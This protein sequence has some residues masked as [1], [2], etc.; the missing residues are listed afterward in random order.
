MS[1]QPAVTLERVESWLTGEDLVF[2]H[3]DEGDIMVGFENCYFAF[4]MQAEGEL[5]LARA[6]WRGRFPVGQ[7]PELHDLAD[8]HHQK[9]YGPRLS[10]LTSPGEE[11]QDSAIL[12]TQMVEYVAQG[13][14][15][16]QLAA[17]M[18]LVMRMNMRLFADIE[19]RYPALV[20]WGDD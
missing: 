12:G 3:D 16:E 8:A 10:V 11:G 18:D 14:S 19:E 4:Y 13:R 6:Y 9:T 15:D 1:T 2:E 7:M 5:L 20:T 17:F